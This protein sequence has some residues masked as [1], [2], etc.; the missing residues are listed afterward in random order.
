MEIE[1]DRTLLTVLRDE[2]GLT[3]TKEGCDDSECGA[4]MVM[5]DGKPVNSCSYLA[6]QADGREITTVEGLAPGGELHPLQRA[7]LAEGGVQCG[8]CT[9]G[10]ADL[11]GGAA[12]RQPAPERGRGAR[13]PVGQ[14]LPLHGLSGHHQRRPPGGRGAGALTVSTS[15][16]EEAIELTRDLI[17]V[18]TSNPPG[19]ETPAAMLL[20]SYLEAAGVECELIARDPDR[21]N[22]VARIPGTGGGPSLALL[23]HTDVVPADAQDWAHPPF[24]GYVDGDGFLWGRGAAD[25]KTETA[26]RAVAI[27]ELARTGFQPRGDLIYI[28]EADEEDGT[29]EVGLIWLAGARPDVRTDLAINEGGGARWELS[30]GRVVYPINIGE[31]ATL[32]ALVTALGE[33]GHASTP[34]AGAN[35]VPRLATLIGRLAA[36]RTRMR[37][38]PETR[39][40]LELLVGPYGRRPPG[41]R[42][43]RGHAAPVVPG[44]AAAP[45][46]LD[47]RADPP[48]R[49]LGAQRDAGPGKRRV[50]LPDPA[51]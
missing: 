21:A 28:A 34:T 11:G 32:P 18:D 31:K 43:P 45:V 7:F 36:Y 35:A 12:R 48:D 33:A 49:V 37:D 15:L 42:H 50:R 1:P 13:R 29:E 9:P 8:F 4:C 2:L 3:G 6:L 44:G 30:D 46:R 5:I 22:L 14:P 47:H 26:V 10:H 23:G 51:G 39:A 25:M 41:R 19:R 40:M 27:A 38:L 16:H 24:S 17:R 20:K